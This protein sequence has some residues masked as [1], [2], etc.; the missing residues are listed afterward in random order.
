MSVF[1]RQGH[2]LLEGPCAP[3]TGAQAPGDGGGGQHPVASRPGCPH[4]AR[5]L[6]TDA[7]PRGDSARGST[8]P[9]ESVLGDTRVQTCKRAVFQEELGNVGK[10]LV[11]RWPGAAGS[12]G[13]G[14]DVRLFC[15]KQA[16]LMEQ[17][18]AHME[19]VH[20]LDPLKL[21]PDLGLNFYE[22]V[23][24]VSFV[25]QQIHQGRRYGCHAR[26]TSRADPAARLAEAKHAPLLPSG[27]TWD[28]PESCF[29]M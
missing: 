8:N 29:H 16:E 15:E 21:K 6:L 23:K 13:R 27:R 12:P 3:C 26:F 24:L 4:C 9:P 11:G 5:L 25:R 10:G 19:K 22:Q 18:C 20:G 2:R 28:R 1:R 17:L 14:P 7:A